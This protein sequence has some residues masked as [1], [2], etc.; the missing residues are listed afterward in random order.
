[1]TTEDYERLFAQASEALAR[2]DWALAAATFDILSSQAPTFRTEEVEAGLFEARVEAGKLALEEGVLNDALR[3]FDHALAIRPDDEE[4]LQLRRLTS[5]YRA[6]VAAFEDEEWSEAADQFRVVYLADPEFLDVRELLAEAHYELGLAY[7]E[8]EI[9]C[10]AA[11][12]YRSSLAVVA[13]RDVE[14]LEERASEQCDTR[15]VETGPSST[16]VPTF[17]AGG[18]ITSAVTVTPVTGTA[19]PVAVGTPTVT[20]TVPALPSP[21][22]RPTEP[23]TAFTFFLSEDIRTSSECGGSYI[24]GYIRAADGAPLP[25]VTILARDFF[26]NQLAATSKDN[27][28]GLYDIPISGD[29]ISYEVAII[30]GDQLLSPQVLLERAEGEPSCYIL[31]WQRSY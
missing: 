2:E 26:G 21:T 27:P 23:P 9:W 3:H 28:P 25:G 29:P 17:D 11:Q 13:D 16:R 22:L 5:A 30:S 4:L 1:V 7:A 6:G 24:Q 12:Q 8:R 31:N 15:I 19:T 10:D 14:A 20:P 18:V